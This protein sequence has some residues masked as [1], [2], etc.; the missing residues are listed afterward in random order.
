MTEVTLSENA[1]HSLRLIRSQKI[2]IRTFF[3]LIKLYQTPLKVVSQLPL[4]LERGNQKNN[5]LLFS[6]E[7]VLE[8]VEKTEKYG[9]RI[10][11][12]FDQEYPSLLREVYDPPPVITMVGNSNFLNK[13]SL[14]VVGS[15]NATINGNRFTYK[16]AK[17]VGKEGFLIISGLA[18]GIDRAAHEASLE[19]GTVAVIAGGIDNIYPP[20]NEDLYYKIAEN[21]LI[22]SE[23]PFGTSPKSQNFPQRNRIISGMCSTTVVVEASPKSGSLITARFAL[24]QN[25]EIFAVPGFPLEPRSQGTNQLIKE[26]ANIVTSIQDILDIIAKTQ[27]KEFAINKF[28]DSADNLDYS[29]NS[30]SEEE[31][32]KT[33][34]YLLHSLS[35]NP[36]SIEDIVSIS[37]ISFRLLL[38]A[39]VELEI[40]RKIIRY[41]G[42]KISLIIEDK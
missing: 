40:N 8:E 33:K 9:A 18:R 22:I 1:I 3:D 30:I 24:E 29:N 19:S 4:M 35:F 5:F 14:A 25:R 13:N 16:I 37:K 10:I 39:I 12:F 20:E 27:N 7:Q 42:N 38:T 15:R 34:K 17:E 31:I 11:S 2:G 36:T 21:G 41:P 28:S 26:G 6:I 32:I 23:M